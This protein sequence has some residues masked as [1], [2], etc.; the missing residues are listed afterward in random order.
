MPGD[1][2]PRRNTWSEM[3]DRRFSSRALT[4]ELRKL[5]DQSVSVTDDGTPLTRAQVLA[6]MIWD[7]ALGGEQKV[8][9]PSGNM[10]TVATPPVAWAMQYC[11]ER[12]EGKAQVA[13][14]DNTDGVRAAD[15]VA[16]L[17]KERLN[18]MATT[19]AGPPIHKPK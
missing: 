5:A 14:N 6:K 4:T 7:M 8:R 15:K 13:Q 9:D 18:K 19:V 10:K 3:S 12:I 2:G 11:F 17:A 1:S 16:A